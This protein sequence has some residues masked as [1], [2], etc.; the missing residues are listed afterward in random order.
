VVKDGFAERSR[1]GQ[2]VMIDDNDAEPRP[3]EIVGVV[4][5]VK[6]ANLE[7]PAQPDMYLPLPQAHKD[8][9]PFLRNSIYCVAKT[10]PEVGGGAYNVSQLRAAIQ[11]VDPNVAVGNVR[12]MTEVLAAA[13]GSRRFS[14]LLIGSFAGAA[15]FLAA[16]GLYAVIS[17]G[18]Q[19][20]TREIGVRLALGAT[21]GR[22]L[23]MIFK[24]GAIL[25]GAGVAIGLA[26]ALLL[27]RLVAS[28][29]YGISEYDPFSFA[30]V[31][32]LLAMISLVACWI[33]SCRTLNVDPV[34]AL[35]CE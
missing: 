16:A 10:N 13:L 3:V 26:I 35:R 30:I 27:A 5:S 7:T 33:A 12:Q 34:V 14:L 17:Y 4:G 28:Q 11:S 9:V 8:G 6:Q 29:M 1:M 22:I 25:L 23:G 18:I 24:E 15:L 19:Q 2:R 21:R 20:R 32:L 31:S